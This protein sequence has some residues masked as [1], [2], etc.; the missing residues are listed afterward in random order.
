MDGDWT[1]DHSTVYANI[2]SLCCTAG[3]NITLYANY[4]SIKKQNGKNENWSEAF[5]WLAI[6]PD[7]GSHPKIY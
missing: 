4:P 5:M 6:K 2:E 1:C 7:F 3:I